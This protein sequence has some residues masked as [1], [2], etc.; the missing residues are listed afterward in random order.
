MMSTLP[1]E[2]EKV[3]KTIFMKTMENLKQLPH[4]RDPKINK[5]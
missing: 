4:E 3:T 5:L 2:K 1:S